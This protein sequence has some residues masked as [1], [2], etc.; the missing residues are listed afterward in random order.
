MPTANVPQ[1]SFKNSNQGLSVYNMN[2]PQQ[3]PQQPAPDAVNASTKINREART[4]SPMTSHV[5]E[6]YRQDPGQ[7]QKD[8]I[9][10]HGSMK[11]P[12]TETRKREMTMKVASKANSGST[13]PMTQ[14]LTNLSNNRVKL[15]KPSAPKPL[16]S[17]STRGVSP[18]F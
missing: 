14:D 12:A 17:G 6:N 9:G 13:M 8:Q 10:Q 18:Q 4:I 15:N 1:Q 3:H 2:Q 7:Q 11:Q 16:M 5:N